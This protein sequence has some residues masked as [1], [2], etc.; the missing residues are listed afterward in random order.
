MISPNVHLVNRKSSVT[1]CSNSV[2]LFGIINLKL[3]HTD[4]K[5]NYIFIIVAVILILVIGYGAYYLALL[6]KQLTL[7]TEQS[8]DSKTTLSPPNSPSNFKAIIKELPIDS[9]SI[10]GAFMENGEVFYGEGHN[11]AEIRTQGSITLSNGAVVKGN[12]EITESDGN[13]IML[14]EGQVYYFER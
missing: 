10:E 13:K 12:G 1:S 2:V 3:M 14:K 7:S 8:I 9:Q 11:F 4:L 6:D 5:R